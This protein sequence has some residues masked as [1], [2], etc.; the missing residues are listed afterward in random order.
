MYAS[1]GAFWNAETDGIWNYKYRPADELG[2][3]VVV[4]IIW[5]AY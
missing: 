4:K 2:M 1:I 3:D 5:M